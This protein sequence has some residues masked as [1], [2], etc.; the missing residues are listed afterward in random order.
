M[1]SIQHVE[2]GA[3]Y[4][5]IMISLGLND[6]RVEPWGPARPWLNQVAD[7]LIGDRLDRLHQVARGRPGLAPGLRQ[8]GLLEARL[9]GET[10]DDPI[11]P[12]LNDMRLPTQYDLTLLPI[13]VSEGLEPS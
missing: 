8:Q 3:H 1:D 4:P 2:K 11:I 12:S 9:D 6:P 13:Q 7:R 5:A 10:G